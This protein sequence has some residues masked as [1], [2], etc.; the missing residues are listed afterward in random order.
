MADILQPVANVWTE[1]LADF[2]TY[3][4]R[5]V[6]LA[7]HLVTPAEQATTNSWADV[8]G[9]TLDTLHCGSVSYTIR[10][11]HGANGLNWRVVASNDATFAASVEAQASALVAAGAAGSY[12]ATVAV[13]RYYKVQVQS[14]VADNAAAAVVVGLAKG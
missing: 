6:A 8:A 2:G 7:A 13:W 14:A 5:V 1:L 3:Q 10:N 9:S 12:S 4:S 11:T